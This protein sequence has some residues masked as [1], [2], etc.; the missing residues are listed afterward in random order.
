LAVVRRVLVPADLD[1]L[2]LELGL[3]A[4][5][6]VALAADG[7]EPHSPPSPSPA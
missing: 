7:A 1:V 4:E 5:D 6:S 2:K 3:W